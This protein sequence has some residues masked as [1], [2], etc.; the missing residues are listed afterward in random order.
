MSSSLR[1]GALAATVLALSIATLSACGAGNDAQTLEVKPDNAAVAV[2]DIKLQNIN[3]I[4]QPELDSKGPAVITGQLFNNGDKDQTLSAVKLPGKKVT[5]QLTG[6]KGA[7]PVVVPAGGSLTLGGK[8][9]ASAVLPNGRESI[10]D[11]EQ[12]Q[13][14]FVFS[15]TGDVRIGAFVVPATH[16]FKEWGPSEA[17]SAPAKSGQPGKQG[18]PASATPS[19]K[20]EEKKG[21]AARNADANAKKNDKNR[22]GTASPDAGH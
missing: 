19:G 2:G 8:G 20:A 10:K 12:Q 22:Q 14:S 18:A 3:V 6:A 15:R 16:Y 17:P 7:G 9:N 1:R 13:L 21:D 4:T 11:G 5:V